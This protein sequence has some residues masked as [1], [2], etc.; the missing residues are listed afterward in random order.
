MLKVVV[1]V[2][3]GPLN[4]VC[5]VGIVVVVVVGYGMVYVFGV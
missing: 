5:V 4:F 3:V 1:V 2:V